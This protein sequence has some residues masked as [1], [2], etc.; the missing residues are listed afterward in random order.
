MPF[1]IGFFAALAVV[2]TTLMFTGK[3]I[4]DVLFAARYYS[5]AFMGCFQEKYF[6]S[7]GI[8][9][10]TGESRSTDCANVRY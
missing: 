9:C 1:S 7:A 10:F 4:S 2:I 8:Q 5:P 6:E 3:L